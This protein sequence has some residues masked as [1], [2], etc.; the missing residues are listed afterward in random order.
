MNVVYIICCVKVSVQKNSENRV[1]ARISELPTNLVAQKIPLRISNQPSELSASLDNLAS[2]HE[3]FWPIDSVCPLALR[4]ITLSAGRYDVGDVHP[5]LDGGN[6]FTD[7]DALSFFLPGSLINQ[8]HLSVINFKER[9][10]RGKQV[11]LLTSTSSSSSSSFYL[12]LSIPD[13]LKALSR[14]HG[15]KASRVKRKKFSLS[16]FLS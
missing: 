1:L 3:R 6:S 14:G 13:F 2:I 7:S 16:I 11:M 8:E 12:P 4:H 10:R 5:F 15:K 9:G